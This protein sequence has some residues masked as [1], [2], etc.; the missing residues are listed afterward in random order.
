M[1]NFLLSTAELVVFI[2]VEYITEMARNLVDEKW[3]IDKLD[4]FKCDICYL[5]E[6]FG[7]G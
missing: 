5:Q 3:S 7:G 2:V 1:P 4:S 6:D